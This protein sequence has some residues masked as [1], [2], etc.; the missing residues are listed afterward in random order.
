MIGYINSITVKQG[1]RPRLM[2][3]MLKGSSDMAGCLAYIVAADTTDPDRL[4]ITEVWD[5]RIS[6]RAS[7]HARSECQIPRLPHATRARY[8]TAADQ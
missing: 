6:I 4:W 7:S 3:L 2:D 8:A 5:S 1:E